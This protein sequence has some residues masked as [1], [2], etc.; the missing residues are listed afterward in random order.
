[1]RKLIAVSLAGGLLAAT[2]ATG[3]ACPYNSASVT[4]KMTV[5]EVE[6]PA[7]DQEAMSTFDPEALKKD[8]DK[9]AE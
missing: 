7:T 1:M 2:T 5:A 6:K 9:K 3:F 4:D 8:A